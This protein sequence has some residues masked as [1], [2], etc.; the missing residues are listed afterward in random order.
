MVIVVASDFIIWFEMQIYDF[1][2]LRQHFI[3]LFV[4]KVLRMASQEF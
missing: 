1:F 3:R 4:F 2:S